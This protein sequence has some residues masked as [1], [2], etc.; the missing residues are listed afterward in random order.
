MS[1]AQGLALPGQL[2]PQRPLQ[3]L[4]LPGSHPQQNNAS[5]HHPSTSSNALAGPSTSNNANG[6]SQSGPK[7][8]LTLEQQHITA[9]D[10]IVP[11]LQ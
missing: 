8:P 11:T 6:S 3:S 7:P 10:G 9:V 4:A 5:N 2:P 1:F